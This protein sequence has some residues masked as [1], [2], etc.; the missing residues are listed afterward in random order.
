MYPSAENVMDPVKQLRLTFLIKKNSYIIFKSLSLTILPKVRLV[1]S[2]F[3][4]LLGNLRIIKEKPTRKTC[5]SREKS[6]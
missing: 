2:W 1:F 6:A 4:D 5:F 3:L